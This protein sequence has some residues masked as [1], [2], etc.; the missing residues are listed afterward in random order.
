MTGAVKLIRARLSSASPGTGYFSSNA[1]ER[2]SMSCYLK[3]T[4]RGLLHW[5][6][7]L[8]LSECEIRVSYPAHPSINY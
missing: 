7:T 2:I 3:R 6:S 1:Q 5:E 8:A 4:V